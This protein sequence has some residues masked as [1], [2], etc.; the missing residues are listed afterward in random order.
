MKTLYVHIGT[1]KTATTSIQM[2]CVDNEAVLNGKGY[3][4]PIL[5]FKFPKVEK[6]RNG[7]FLVGGLKKK[8]GSWDLE[9]DEKMYQKGRDMVHEAFEKT[10]NVILSDENLWNSS[11]TKKFV[12]WNRLV[13]DSKEYGYQIKVIVY[14]RRQDELANSWLAQQ[15]IEGWGNF[16]AVKWDKFWRSPKFLILDYASH[17][18][19]I[20][21]V[22]GKE[23]IIVRIFER[24]KFKGNDHSIYSDFLDAVGLEYTDEFRIVNQETNASITGN[25]QEIRRIMNTILPREG[26]E[27][28]AVRHYAEDVEALK[29]KGNNYIMLS[30]ADSNQF[31]K[32]YD[33]GNKDIAKTYL[34]STE[35]LFRKGVKPGNVWKRE[36]PFM[37]EDVIRFFGLIYMDQ[38]K[39]IW[40]L[41]DKIKRMEE[42]KEE[43]IRMSENVGYEQLLEKFTDLQ[44]QMDA[45]KQEQKIVRKESVQTENMVNGVMN[46]A[47]SLFQSMNDF[48][49]HPLGHS[50]KKKIKTIR[51]K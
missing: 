11:G 42:S 51:T 32:A 18:E 14:L 45:L 41:Q 35:P 5:N 43:A 19:K 30:E 2:F 1:P 17:I 7:H 40:E 29:S 33:E 37:I 22:V 26:K 10:E 16:R 28:S 12:F 20:A 36:N 9:R 38:A 39:E 4:Y 49:N 23:I 27:R 50:V 8:D 48:L 34:N 31:M 13:E 25:S 46:E 44:K 3:S 21:N 6:R 24:D 47:W 15:V